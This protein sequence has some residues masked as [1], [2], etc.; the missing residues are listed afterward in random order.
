[1]LKPQAFCYAY[2]GAQFLPQIVSMMSPSL[3][4]FWAFNVHH[5]GANPRMWSKHLMVSS[6]PV[7]VYT[8]GKVDQ[9]QLKWCINDARKEKRSKQFHPWQQSEGFAQTQIE[10]RTQSN[11][12]VLD[13]FMGSGTTLVAARNLG[14]RAIGIEIEEKYCRIAIDRL[15]AARK[16]AA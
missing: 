6:K 1:M 9:R 16:G 2:I 5:G 12:L 4:W 14:R 13:P 7:L 11:G 8:N 15:E 10:L 3:T